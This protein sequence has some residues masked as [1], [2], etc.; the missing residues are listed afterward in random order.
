M[1]TTNNITGDKIK[2]KPGNDSF[3]ENFDKIF[4]TKD[5]NKC[6]CSECKCKKGE[7]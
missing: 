5:E 1:T 4:G 6:K 2:T 7:K 3:R